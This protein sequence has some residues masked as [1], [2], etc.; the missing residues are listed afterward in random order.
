M[1]VLPQ[2]MLAL[3]ILRIIFVLLNLSMSVPQRYKQLL[4]ILDCILIH[5]NQLIT[6]LAIEFNILHATEFDKS[7]IGY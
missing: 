2:T 6:S 7:M 1:S 5:R 4:L 3:H